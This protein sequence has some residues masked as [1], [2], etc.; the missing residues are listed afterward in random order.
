MPISHCVGM[1]TLPCQQRWVG[2]HLAILRPPIL[3]P[4]PHQSAVV[5][6]CHILTILPPIHVYPSR[7]HHP[8]MAIQMHNS[9]SK[10]LPAKSPAPIKPQ[11]RAT[12]SSSKSP[13]ADNINA[14]LHNINL[15]QNRFNNIL[16]TL[17]PQ[18]GREEPGADGFNYPCNLAPPPDKNN[19]T[20]YPDSPTG[21]NQHSTNK[22]PSLENSTTRISEGGSPTTNPTPPDRDVCINKSP[23]TIL[24]I[25]H[26]PTTSTDLSSRKPSQPAPNLVVGCDPNSDGP[27][28]IHDCSQMLCVCVFLASG[29]EW[30]TVMHEILISSAQTMTSLPYPR[31]Q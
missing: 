8:P 10:E 17:G 19:S 12:C 3:L 15:P 27:R 18:R 22:S 11:Q 9:S 26:M 31:T 20:Y 6:L 29:Y 5:V 24:P 7:L 4:Y 30:V 2:T 25:T 23:A 13:R 28:E 14:I 1:H 16:A 21:I